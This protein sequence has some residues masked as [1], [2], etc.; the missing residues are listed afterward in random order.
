M[1]KLH[2]GILIAVLLLSMCA[3]AAA[4]A[5]NETDAPSE[6]IDTTVKGAAVVPSESVAKITVST[7]PESDT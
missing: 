6:S 7:L 1:K 2:F 3:C 4:S 5:T